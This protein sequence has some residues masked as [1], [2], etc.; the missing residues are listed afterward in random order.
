MADSDIPAEACPM[1]HTTHPNRTPCAD[2]PAEAVEAAARV[3]RDWTA[4]FV[5]QL[6]AGNPTRD[7]LIDCAGE[8]LAA[9]LPHIRARVLA[10]VDAALRHHLNAVDDPCDDRGV[11]WPCDVAD[12]LHVLGAGGEREEG[13]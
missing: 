13:T 9:A 1:C 2:I 6:Q 8:V 3:F 4:V 11:E 10:E 12:A 7:M 5:V